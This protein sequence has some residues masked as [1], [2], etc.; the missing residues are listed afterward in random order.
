M[1]SLL[2][3]RGTIRDKVDRV[4]SK[5]QTNI[6]GATLLGTKQMISMQ[7][8]R[9]KEIKTQKKILN[10]ERDSRAELDSIS[11]SS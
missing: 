7:S 5:Y 10:D 11:H 6:I 1:A 8:V 4:F 2:Q 9:D 3:R